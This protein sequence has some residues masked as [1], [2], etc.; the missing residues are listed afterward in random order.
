MHPQDP[1]QDPNH[2]GAQDHIQQ[3]DEVPTYVKLWERT[4]R[5]I[6]ICLLYT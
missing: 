5:C 4:K 6:R 1:S 3:I 2:D